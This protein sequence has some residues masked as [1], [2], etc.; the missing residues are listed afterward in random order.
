MRPLARIVPS[1]AALLLTLLASSSVAVAAAE[2]ACVNGG[3]QNPDIAA[4]KSALQ[5]SPIRLGK[6]LE[7]AN[8]LERAG[9]YAEAVHVLEEGQKY[10]PFNPA[11]QFSLRRARNR[12]NEEHYLEGINQAEA[13]AQL[14][15]R[16]DTTAPAARSSPLATSGRAHK[17]RPTRVAA[18]NADT[19][20]M[21]EPQN[22]S[23]VAEATRSN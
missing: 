18:V 8:L 22:F 12:L 3:L 15:Q 14:K 5:Q 17:E 10:N 13:S 20:A 9:C 2:S 21:V 19:E 6:R 4:G 16:Q 23:N 7:V 11:L 1:V